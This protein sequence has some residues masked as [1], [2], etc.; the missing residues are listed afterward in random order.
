MTTMTNMHRRH[1][2]VIVTAL[3]LS[4]HK[5]LSL[6]TPQSIT[7][8][9]IA[10]ITG[11]NK[12]IGKEIARRLGTDPDFTAIIAARDPLLGKEA[13]EDILANPG[14]L[15][16]HHHDHDDEHDDGNG[17]DD[18][19]GGE[20]DDGYKPECDVISL[21]MPLD[22]TDPISINN[23]ANYI[24]ET[25]GVLDVLIN[26]AAICFNDPTLYGRVEYT[27][28]Q[29]QAGITIDTNFFGTLKVSEAFLPLLKKSASPRIVNI[30]SAAGRLTILRSH[31]LVEEFTSD[32]LT[33]PK[34]SEM[35][36]QFVKDV[37][38][39]SHLEKGWPN[40]CYGVSKLGIIAL[41]HVM[42]RE[43]P[44]MMINSV[45]PGYCRTDQNDNQGTV[46][47]FDGAY[48]PYLL[49][50]ME[51]DSDD[52]GEDEEG[53]EDGEALEPLSGLH[54]YQESE[55]PWTYQF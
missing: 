11:A 4:S 44:D 6:T 19:E 29:K 27:P 42:A 35:M 36:R 55:I 48:T 20:N 3:F 25:Y 37:E 45:D 23:A 15:S 21:P 40:T 8:K 30:A 46:D 34:L 14:E 47:P 52:Y 10:L 9:R 24:E 54:F 22:L 1:R 43:H 33:V 17:L 39:G 2:A 31:Q 32:K 26:N 28:F 7:R 12:G 18:D 49:S 50:L 16:I 51:V 13:A 38:D 41:T 5:A 53:T